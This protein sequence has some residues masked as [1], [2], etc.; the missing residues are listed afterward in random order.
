LEDL[1]RKADPYHSHDH[2]EDTHNDK[3]GVDGPFYLGEI[4]RTEELGNHDGAT[5]GDPDDQCNEGVC[6][7]GT[8]NCVQDPTAKNGDPCDDGALCTVNDTC[9]NGSCSGSATDCSSLNDQC[10]VGACDPG[11]GNCF[12][13]TVSK[14]G[15]PCDDG[16]PTTENDT[17]SDGVCMGESGAAAIPTLSEWGMIIFMTI[18]LGLGV[19]TILRRRVEQRSSIR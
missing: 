12:Q 10:N 15:D 18:I 16:D 13:D 1:F 9:D 2:C 4:F 6:D 11:T 17:C 19:I 14:D 5:C 8:G 3:N 7:P